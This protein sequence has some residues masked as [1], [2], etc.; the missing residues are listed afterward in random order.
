T[1][2][3]VV[4]PTGMLAGS[5]KLRLLPAP[6]PITTTMGLAPCSISRIAFSC[7]PRKRAPG[8]WIVSSRSCMSVSAI[9]LQRSVRTSLFASS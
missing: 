5:M 4:P 9:R 1:T 7:R 6:V 8:P 3:T 2:T